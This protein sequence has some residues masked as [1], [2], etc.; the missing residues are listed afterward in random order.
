MFSKP[1]ANIEKPL[2]ITRMCLRLR[3]DFAEIHNNLGVVL[4]LT[5]ENEKAI[6][7]FKQLLKLKPDYLNAYINLASAYALMHR[8]AEAVAAA[9][10]AL[11]L[12]RSQGQTTLAKQIEEWLNSYRAGLLDIQKTY[13]PQPKSLPHHVKI[14]NPFMSKRKKSS[15]KSLRLKRLLASILSALLFDLRLV[16]R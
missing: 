4:A 10:K 16:L 11:E 6:E 7:H 5:G 8:S 9:Q 12:A 3:P 1:W 14:K 15:K 13:C 2:I